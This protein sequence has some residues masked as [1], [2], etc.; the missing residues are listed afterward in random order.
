MA[1][2]GPGAALTAYELTAPEFPAQPR[3]EGRARADVCILGAGFT[4]LSAAIELAEAGLSVIVLEGG[5]VGSGASGRN[6]GQ[7]IFGYSKEQAQIEALVG[8]ETSQQ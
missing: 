7:V 4:G 1:A 8:L 2:S 6:G 5:S 3:L